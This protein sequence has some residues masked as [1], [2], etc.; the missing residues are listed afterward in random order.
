[1][2]E[3]K[4]SAGGLQDLKGKLCRRRANNEILCTQSTDV[5]YDIPFVQHLRKA[6]QNSGL[7]RELQHAGC[8][9]WI[10]SCSMDAVENYRVRRK[11]R[12]S[13]LSSFH[14]PMQLHGARSGPSSRFGT[15]QYTNW[16]FG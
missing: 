3:T 6:V 9:F 13:S 15:A 4:Q 12:S 14:H 10:W 2:P 7:A 11:R 8:T 16:R 5:Q 1:M